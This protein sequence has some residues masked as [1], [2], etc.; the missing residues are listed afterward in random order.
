[1]A[2]ISKPILTIAIPTWNRGATLD[3]AL[4]HI[5]PQIGYYTNEIEIIVS[6]NASEDNTE[7]IVTNQHLKYPGTRFIYNKNEINVGFFG[8]CKKCK[9]ISTGEYMWLLS[10]D[11]FVCPGV[12]KAIINA[13]TS[14]EDTAIIYLKNNPEYEIHKLNFYEKEDIIKNET[15]NMGLIS[16]IIFFNRKDN[17]GE[18]FSKFKGAPFMGFI[19]LLNAFNF[20]NKAAVIEGNCLLGAMAVPTGYNYFDVFING[21][22]DVLAYMKQIKISKNVILKFRESYLLKFL[23]PIYGKF[24]IENG[25]S[26]G[27]FETSDIKTINSWLQRSYGDLFYFWAVFYPFMIFPPSFSKFALKFKRKFK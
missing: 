15:F 2:P 1:M 5:M 7:E 3:K 20:K 25:L 19:F 8:N 22:N 9:E 16:S 26:F 24:K 6:D 4:D 17:D 27:K 14:K 11:D 23:L 18:L 21:M 12:I 13:L 10:D